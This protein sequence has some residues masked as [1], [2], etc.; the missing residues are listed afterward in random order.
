[1]TVWKFATRFAPQVLF[2]EDSSP[3]VAGDHFDRDVADQ[4]RTQHE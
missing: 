1:M 3:N 4:Q 2:G